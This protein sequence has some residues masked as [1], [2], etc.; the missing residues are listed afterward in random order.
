MFDKTP[1]Y[2]LGVVIR[3][4]GIKP[5]TLRAWERRYGLPVPQRTQGGHRLYS[6]YDIETI[7]WLIGRQKEGMRIS[8]IVKHWQKMI[9][10]GID[11]LAE[12][13]EEKKQEPV[14]SE[15]VS[16]LILSEL[17]EKWIQA[18][19]EFDENK[20]DY[21]LTQSFALY[22]L[23][24]VCIEIL[25]F[26][27]SQIGK[28]WYE[29][30]ASV[31]QEHFASSVAVRR[32]NTLISA[33][34]PPERSEKIITAC[35]PHEN[36][37]FVTLLLTLF[38]RNRGW[39][40]IHLGQNVPYE[41][42][43]QTIQ[44]VGADLTILVA[45]TLE[46]ASVLPG[47]VES[48]SKEKTMLAYGGYIFSQHPSMTEWI[49]AHFLGDNLAESPMVVET[50]LNGKTKTTF[51]KQH[52]QKMSAALTAFSNHQLTIEAN[53]L[54][55]MHLDPSL[56]QFITNADFHFSK[57]LITA[58]TYEDFGLLEH[59]IDLVRA[60]AGSF[61]FNG[62]TINNYLRVYYQALIAHLDDHGE[63]ILE[64]LGHYLDQHAPEN[65]TGNR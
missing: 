5:D 12:L 29:N 60:L 65:P 14:V 21:I 35:V 7:K 63:P 51:A 57:K 41:R 24:T 17:R 23:E 2:N 13:Q 54:E 44:S 10:D 43:R 16:G 4:T 8:N 40:V 59:E 48:L 34:P 11:P 22:P 3:E 47:L 62:K 9:N 31:Q 64:W 53:V 37:S 58:L 32:L 28:L 33:A 25:Q 30:K 56:K 61:G 46:T 38:L 27:L 52:S 19:L 26:G 6:E 55:D 50:I 18:C 15:H 49:D 1:R 20:A 39:Q 45:M 42:M 36:H